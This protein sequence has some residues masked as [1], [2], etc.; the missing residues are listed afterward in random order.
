MNTVKWK[1]INIRTCSEDESS[2]PHWNLLLYKL[3]YKRI[4]NNNNTN[5]K[6]NVNVQEPLT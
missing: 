3:H 4:A 6:R 1:K 5:N 2:L